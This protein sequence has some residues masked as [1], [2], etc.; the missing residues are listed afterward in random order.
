MRSENLVYKVNFRIDVNFLDSG[1][2]KS[3]IIKSST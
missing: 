3:I 1:T 2:Y